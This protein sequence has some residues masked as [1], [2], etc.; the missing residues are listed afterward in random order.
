MG[1]PELKAE[2]ESSAGE[3]IRLMND[4]HFYIYFPFNDEWAQ[5]TRAERVELIDSI[6]IALCRENDEKGM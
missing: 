3:A 4:G 6:K 1:K 2:F 5:A